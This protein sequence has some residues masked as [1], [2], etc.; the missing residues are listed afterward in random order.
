MPVPTQSHRSIPVVTSYTRPPPTHQLNVTPSTSYY[1]P[2]PSQSHNLV[3]DTSYTQPPPA[4]IYHPPPFIQ[5]PH[6]QNN[7]R[8]PQSS[9]TG[10]PHHGSAPPYQY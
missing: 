8:A 6:G 10:Y 3:L 9:Q 5:P 7:S 1:Q 2:N 4:G